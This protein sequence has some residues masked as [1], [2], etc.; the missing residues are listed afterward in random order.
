MENR[1]QTIASSANYAES[2][3]TAASAASTQ[4]CFHVTFLGTRT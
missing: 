3:R 2:V 1:E 4:S